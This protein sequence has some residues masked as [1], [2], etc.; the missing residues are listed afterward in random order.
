MCDSKGLLPRDS[1]FLDDAL[2]RSEPLPYSA[3]INA[4]GELVALYPT[5]AI[6]A[7]KESQEKI[8]MKGI[9]LLVEISTRDD[10]L[11]TSHRTMWNEAV[12]DLKQH[13][14]EGSKALATLLN[15]M[16]QCRA[17]KIGP[18]I[19]AAKKVSPTPELISALESITTAS[20]LASALGYARFRPEI[21]GAG[22]IG[23]TDGE[24]AR[25]QGLA[26]EALKA[27]RPSR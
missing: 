18:V 17:R 1:R 15:E 22:K 10:L 12:E 11:G 9:D 7:W 24:A 20:P 21:A 8:R 2:V 26:S 25:V 5:W 6:N 27:L 19:V 3:R 4:A 13:G 16:L 14:E 23:W